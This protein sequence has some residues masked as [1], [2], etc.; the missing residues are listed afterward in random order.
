M[1]C[2][3]KSLSKGS[4][5]VYGCGYALHRDY[6]QEP[7]RLCSP[8]P[9]LSWGTK[10]AV[11]LAKRGFKKKPGCGCERREETINRWV[12]RFYF[13]LLRLW[14]R[15]RNTKSRRRKQMAKTEQRCAPGKDERREAL[16]MTI[17]ARP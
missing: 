9:S 17:T 12:H 2:H 8:R 1:N 14:N 7:L 5:C 13:A 11:F 3:W 16:R 6:D 10:V 4:K 15:L